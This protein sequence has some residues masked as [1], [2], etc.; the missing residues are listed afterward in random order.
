MLAFSTKKQRVQSPNG[1]RKRN[2]LL[3][4]AIAKSRPA[5][6]RLVAAEPHQLFDRGAKRDQRALAAPVFMRPL[7]AKPATRI[8]GSL[9]LGR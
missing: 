5:G 4:A 7:T 6:R 9:L 3:F 1:L 2:G 8:G